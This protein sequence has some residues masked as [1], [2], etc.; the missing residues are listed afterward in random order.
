MRHTVASH[1]MNQHYGW[2]L[3]HL[4]L[5][6]SE[7]KNKK[8]SESLLNTHESWPTCSQTRLLLNILEN[9]CID[10]VSLI[11]SLL[12]RSCLSVFTMKRVATDN[13]STTC[14]MQM[15]R[16]VS[17]PTSHTCCLCSR[18][19]NAPKCGLRLVHSRR[20]RGDTSTHFSLTATVC[21]SAT[22]ART[23]RRCFVQCVW[24][25][26]SRCHGSRRFRVSEWAGARPRLRGRARA[27]AGA[28][29]RRRRS[30]RARSP[31]AGARDGKEEEKKKT[32][33]SDSDS[34]LPTG[35]NAETINR[36]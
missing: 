18:F 35:G 24:V 22:P 25:F 26:R 7:Y 3:W 11:V 36:S 34:S 15:T 33:C 28:S 32:I 2:C 21:D 4:V 1:I 14:C 29:R 20:A 27:R 10:S 9:D 5:N 17:D 8:F 6:F 13:K 31:S 19:K 12:R 16:K 30:T 23:A